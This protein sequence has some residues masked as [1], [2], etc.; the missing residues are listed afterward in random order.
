MSTIVVIKLSVTSRKY[1]LV[2][3]RYPLSI[4]FDSISY[5]KKTKFTKQK[6]WEKN[7]QRIISKPHAHVH[8]MQKRS[9]KF[10]NNRWKTKRS[11]AHKVP[12]IFSSER[13]IELGDSIISLLK[14]QII[15]PKWLIQSIRNLNSSEILCL[16]WLPTGLIKNERVSL[17]TPFSHYKSMGNFSDTKGH[18][19]I[20]GVVQS[21]QIRTHSGFYACPRYLQV[22]KGSDK[23]TTEKRWRHRFP[24]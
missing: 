10:Q 12:S 8:S 17:E 13:S 23:K 20:Q 5:W 18:L 7:D 1:F 6:K 11:W 9:E 2:F 14:I 19:T 22:W 15:T 21:G 24:H 3:N 16:S 4:H